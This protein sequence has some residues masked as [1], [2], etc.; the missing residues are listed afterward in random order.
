MAVEDMIE[1]AEA[2]RS[3]FWRPLLLLSAIL[4]IIIAS[5]IFGMG[6]RLE[7]VRDWIE[8]LGFWGPAVFVFIYTFTTVAAL[9]GSVMS[10]AAGS[11][12]GP[13]AGVIVVWLGAVAGA[14]LAFLISRYFAR[15][16]VERWLT[17]H[18]KFQHLDELS[19]RYGSVLVAFTRLVPIFPFVLLNYGFGLTRISFRTYLFWTALC[20]IPGDILYVVGSAALFEG[21]SEG[22]IPWGLIVIVAVAAVIVTLLARYARRKIDLDRENQNDLLRKGTSER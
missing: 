18:E 14:S 13:L 10:V 11:L 9:P 21:I 8:S 15:D 17:S 4:A 1:P 5:R 2:G 3:R 16:S 7:E 20:I 6:D 19:G 12:F 22:R